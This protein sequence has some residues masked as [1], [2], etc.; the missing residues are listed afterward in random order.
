MFPLVIFFGLLN[1]K[2]HNF[3][4]LIKRLSP[5]ESGTVPQ[6]VIH[7][8]YFSDIGT[9]VITGK[10]KLIDE[11][12]SKLP[13]E[14]FKKEIKLVILSK[15][16][17]EIGKSSFDGFINLEKVKF[18]QT[19]QKIGDFAFNGCSNLVRIKFP[20]SLKSIGKSAFSHCINLKTIRFSEGL[21]SIDSNS[22]AYCSKLVSVVIPASVTTIS[23]TAF[24]N[25]D[26][27]NSIKYSQHQNP[28]PHSKLASNK[29]PLSSSIFE[30]PQNIKEISDSKSYVNNKFGKKPAAQSIENI[31][32]NPF[33]DPQPVNSA[34]AIS[35]ATSYIIVGV[36]CGVIIIFTI[37]IVILI[38]NCR[39]KQRILA[40][41]MN[42]EEEEAKEADDVNAGIDHPDS[43]T[44]S[45]Y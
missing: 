16:I 40:E 4:T 43:Q 30:S 18:P 44:E 23:T 36:I 13:W 33:D 26:Q 41:D 6:T 31:D 17:T 7:Y 25:C 29:I 24:T 19:L 35:N 21:E 37:I 22:F 34:Q 28:S 20:S 1:Y 10:G 8:S 27:L 5:T 45:S 14:R 2:S 11:S 38:C 9:L 39:R 32:S 42:E 12:N 15:G 3:P